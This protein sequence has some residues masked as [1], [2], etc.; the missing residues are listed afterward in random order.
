MKPWR[1]ANEREKLMRRIASLKQQR[2]PLIPVYRELAMQF[3]PSNGRFFHEKPDQY[4]RDGHFNEVVDSSGI[5]AVETSVAGLMSI[6][7]PPSGKWIK[8]TTRDPDLDK[9]KPVQTWLSDA[10]HVTLDVFSS[11]NTYIALPQYYRELLTFATAAGLLLPHREKVVCH[12]PFT[13][14]EYY[15]AENDEHE[16]NVL[17]REFHMSVAQ[18][19]RRFGYDNLSLKVQQ[20]YREGHLDQVHHIAQLIEPREDR[21]SEGDPDERGG[22]FRDPG[23]L[24]KRNMPFRSVYWEMAGDTEG[25]LDEG[26][27]EKFPAI[28]PRWDTCGGDAYGTGP[29]NRALPHSKRLQILTKRLARGIHQQMD[30]ATIW[31]EEFK[32]KEMDTNPGGKTFGNIGTTQAGVRALHDVRP[33]LDH[34]LLQL[35]DIRAQLESAFFAKFFAQST[36]DDRNQ[37]ATAYEISKM[38]RESWLM[39]GPFAQRVFTEMLSPMTQITFEQLL[40]NGGFDPPPPELQGR[41]VSVRMIS[42]LAQAQEAAGVV[43]DDEL[44]FAMSQVFP[45]KPSVVHSFN[46]NAYIQ[47]RAAKTGADPELVRSQEE[48]DQLVAAQN[49][50]LAATEQAKLMESQSKAVKNLGSTPSA[51]AGD[52][53]L[54][55]VGSQ[56][57]GAGQ[58]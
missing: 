54:S 29:G 43:A 52:T 41:I 50:A 5:E 13:C 30:P 4:T 48:V 19:R 40:M 12:Y 22:R 14:G 44:V 38:E 18:M 53:A 32:N 42:P 23:K 33:Q 51:A 39:L 21:M 37:R 17:A 11:G 1:D 3:A 6:A 28:T 7:S 25:V 45:M 16:V 26:G 35:Q 31:P 34:G 47:R 55:D 27:F 36:N 46:E 49:K 57:A 10:A 58:Q 56:M 2:S 15:I 9:F 24:D 8:F 20:Q